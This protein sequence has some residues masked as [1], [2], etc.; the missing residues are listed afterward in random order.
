[1]NS[2]DCII[3]LYHHC[4]YS[5]LITLNELKLRIL[6]TTQ[7]NFMVRNDPVCYKAKEL[8]RKEWSLK[9]Y[10]DKRKSTNLYRFDFCPGC[11]KQINWKEIKNL[12]I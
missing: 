1:M 2:H 6:E 4:D 5:E 10:A 9:D 11:G 8:Y 12:N 3:G 7:Y